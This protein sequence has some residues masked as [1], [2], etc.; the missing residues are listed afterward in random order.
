[1]RNVRLKYPHAMSNNIL[2]TDGYAYRPSSK[3]AWYLKVLWSCDANCE[4]ECMWPMVRVCLKKGWQ[5]PQFWGKVH[6]HKFNRKA[7]LFTYSEYLL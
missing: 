6:F 1:M 7:F 5:V 4:Y 2:A 3:N